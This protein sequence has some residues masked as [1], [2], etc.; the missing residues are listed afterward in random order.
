MLPDIV[1]QLQ[2][3]TRS[4]LQELLKI[5]SHGK[6]PSQE[7]VAVGRQQLVD[8]R[9]V[10]G[11]QVA[12]LLATVLLLKQSNAMVKGGIIGRRI[13]ADGLGCRDDLGGMGIVG[14]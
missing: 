9:P 1:R 5:R 10:G 12:G 2:R 11:K 6:P 14:L 4:E 8:T 13:S 3:G 7:D